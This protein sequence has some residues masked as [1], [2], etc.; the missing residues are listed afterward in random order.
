MSN[1][2]KLKVVDFTA[3]RI[4]SDD[5]N[6]NIPFADNFEK[7]RTIQ[8]ANAV[9]GAYVNRN[10]TDM[11]NKADK[12]EIPTKLSELE[13]D[14]GYITSG[15]IPSKTS[16]LT[17]DG[18]NGIDPFITNQVNDLANYT[19]NTNLTT[20]LNNKASTTDLNNVKS[21]IDYKSTDYVGDLV[22]ESIRSKNIFNY[23][24]GSFEHSG[25]DVSLLDNGI[26]VTVND[27]NATFPRANYFILDI[28]NHLG[29]NITL[30]STIDINS[31][32][33]PR[34]AIGTCDSTGGNRDILSYTD[35]E[36]N[37]RKSVTTTLPTSVTPNTD[38]YF[39]C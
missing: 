26:K 29:E 18:E 34:I 28:L 38:F 16:D 36:T 13:N 7:T 37:G 21:A 5:I 14:E 15:D 31:T 17:N 39:T 9:I 8:Q 4:S 20:L 23:K 33:H 22:V 32:A 25:T 6:T 12:D 27:S 30:S 2:N 10:Y 11:Q 1:L 35:T 3:G 19:N 24:M